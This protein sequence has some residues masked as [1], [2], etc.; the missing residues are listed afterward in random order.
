MQ[1]T[2]AALQAA[3]IDAPADRTVRLVY[4]D[5]LDESGDPV[6]AAR[7][8]FIRTQIRLETMAD[9]DPERAP[10]AARCEELFAEHWIDWWRPVCTAVGLPVP[11]V[12][13]HRFR[14]RVKR[15]VRTERER[16]SPY[17]AHPNAW[18]L[19]SEEHGFTTQFIAGFPE[20]VYFYHLPEGAEPDTFAAWAGAV[21]LAR[22]R[23]G[24]IL[25]EHT[26]PAVDGPHLSGVTNLTLDELPA[27][28]APLVAGSPHLAGL[29]TLTIQSNAL[30]TET[31][32]AL[33]VYPTWT[34]LRTLVLSGIQSPDAILALA[35]QTKL[36]EL[37][38]LAL[39]ITP[40][41]DL[42]AAFGG[43]GSILQGFMQ[44]LGGII[45]GLQQ[46]LGPLWRDFWPAIDALGAAP[47]LGQLRR[48]SITDGRSFPLFAGMPMPAPIELMFDPE[49]ILSDECIRALAAGLNPNRLVRLELPAARLSPAA[50][51]ELAERFGTRVV[52]V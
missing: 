37:D 25:T 12:P 6:H 13:Q 28:V 11:F 45:S 33:V 46:T 23:F 14:D 7:A 9:D 1:D 50:R 44:A 4:A 21:P 16:G 32:R 19:R 20:L 40:A 22:L 15:L 26:W 5:A 47:F 51:T 36:T 38:D 43:T 41:V 30:A 27:A 18:S 48:L 24:P 17:T 31:V 10:L 35:R 49:A 34:G 39:R 29:T 8:E 42:S 52:L 3:L 2:L